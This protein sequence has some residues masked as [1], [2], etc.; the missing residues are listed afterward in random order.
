[1]WLLEGQAKRLENLFLGLAS[2]TDSC[3]YLRAIA[4]FGGRQ[5]PM[6]A[7]SEAFFNRKQPHTPIELVTAREIEQCKAVLLLRID[8]DVNAAGDRS[9]FVHLA[10]AHVHFFPL[11]GLR[12]RQA[13]S[14]L[15]EASVF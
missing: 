9:P 6:V 15:E 5:E 7:Q 11:G 3:A 1:M 4:S 14:L 8:L 2:Y 12:M 13:E 10:D